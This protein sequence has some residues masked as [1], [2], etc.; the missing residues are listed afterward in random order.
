[1]N[2][3]ERIEEIEDELWIGT[4]L[5]AKRTMPIPKFVCPVCEKTY[6]K[7]A[8]GYRHVYVEHF[9]FWEPSH[10]QRMKHPM[11]ATGKRCWCN[12]RMTGIFF[13]EQHCI[14]HGGIHYHYHTNMIGVEP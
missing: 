11:Q 13:F 5:E 2:P 4:H 7:P 1:M 10:A 14:E 12:K 6:L 3:L 8:Y 9:E